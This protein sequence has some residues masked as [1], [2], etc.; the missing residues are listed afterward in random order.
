MGMT[1]AAFLLQ[2]SQYQGIFMPVKL[3]NIGL[4]N[5]GTSHYRLI[6]SIDEKDLGAVSDMLLGRVAKVS[7]KNSS[8][9]FVNSEDL[10]QSG[11][12]DSVLI[13]TPLSKNLDHDS[14]WNTP[15]Y[16]TIQLN[17]YKLVSTSILLRQLRLS[18][19][20]GRLRR[21]HLT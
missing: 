1:T 10:L 9:G 19:H 18:S 21:R 12:C 16:P 15:P 3:G 7:E 14:R 2:T 6:G 17:H 5:I 4:G 11:L 13:A 20:L 8:A